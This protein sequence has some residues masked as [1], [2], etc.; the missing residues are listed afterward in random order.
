MVVTYHTG[1]TLAGLLTALSAQCGGVVVVDNGSSERELA[2]PE[3]IRASCRAA[4]GVLLEQ[5]RNTGI[6]AAQNRG[7]EYARRRGFGYV[8]LSDDDSIP[9]E[10]MVSTLLAGLREGNQPAGG[11]EDP[12]ASSDPAR[13]VAAVGPLI[14]EDKPGGDQLVYVARRWGPRRATAAELSA[15]RLRV[16]FLLASGCLVD[17]AAL[18]QVGPMNEEMFIDHVDLEWGL[19]A[20]RAGYD[21][22]VLPAARMRHSL[23]DQTAHVPGRRQ[24]VHVHGPV[25]GYYLMRNTVVLIRS[26]L[27]PWAWRAGYVVWIGKYLAFNTIMVDRRRERARAMGRGLCDGLRGR[28]GPAPQRLIGR[29]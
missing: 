16:A 15:R 27:M 14:E 20:R 9:D 3:G 26:G 10:G 7:I 21:L 6:A 28:G 29:R 12:V 11:S 13:A 25:R 22:L 19:R 18:E 17:L 8:L 4:G 5:G 2:G 24:P 1:P 23:G